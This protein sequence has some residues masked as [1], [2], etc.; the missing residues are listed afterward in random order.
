M[1]IER[2]DKRYRVEWDM[3]IGG[4]PIPVMA[5]YIVVSRGAKKA[6]VR[7]IVKGVVRGALHTAEPRAIEVRFLS[8]KYAALCR[9]RDVEFDKISQASAAIL[10]ARENLELLKV[11]G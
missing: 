9:A 5:E 2:G 7:R 11:L 10:V 8:T 6:S 3:N 1:T 4:D